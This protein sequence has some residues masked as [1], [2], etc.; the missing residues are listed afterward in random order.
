[1]IGQP[2]LVVDPNPAS[3]G[4]IVTVNG[5]YFTPQSSVDLKIGDWHNRWI[6][7]DSSGNWSTSLSI[8]YFLELKDYL[9]IATDLN[10]ISV[11]TTLTLSS[12]SNA[13]Q[14]PLDEILNHINI[15]LSTLNNTLTE[16]LIQQHN[17]SL[18][19]ITQLQELIHEVNTTVT[20]ILYLYTNSSLDQSIEKLDFTILGL[21]DSYNNLILQTEDLEDDI[22]ELKSEIV[23]MKEELYK[24]NE[25]INYLQENITDFHH[26]INSIE[27]AVWVVL[28]I[29][30]IL[31]L[32]FIFDIRITRVGE[33][34]RLS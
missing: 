32:L 2:S 6:D 21:I 11:S 34:K 4:A 30:L 31:S 20:E 13:T 24:I 25:D 28:A 17:Y 14:D 8:P 29:T 3:Y 27:T 19:K 12:T 16:V 33:R 22:I 5:Y 18:L 10:N 23:D 9:V 15:Q 26:R 7:T 1:V